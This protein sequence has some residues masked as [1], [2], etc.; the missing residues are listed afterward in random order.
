MPTHQ[1]IAE[2]PAMGEQR[3]RAL[4]WLTNAPWAAGASI[5]ERLLA[6]RREQGLSQERLAR[7]LGVDP[8]TLS[9]WERNLRVP[10]AGYLRS[11]EALVE[12]HGRTD[13]LPFSHPADV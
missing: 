7:R 9:R 11:A 13:P 4:E 10:S 2:W 3:P 5:G 12:R 1:Q 6:F 8:G